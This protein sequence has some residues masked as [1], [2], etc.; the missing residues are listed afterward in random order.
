MDTNGFLA[1]RCAFP[2]CQANML[3]APRYRALPACTTSCSAAIVSSTGVSGAHRVEHL[4]RE[5]VVVAAAEVLGEQPA[6]DL[7]ADPERVDVGVV[8]EGDTGLDG[9]TDVRV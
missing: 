7:L 3:D 5:Y 2:S 1:T 6:G 4:G 9:V 8:E